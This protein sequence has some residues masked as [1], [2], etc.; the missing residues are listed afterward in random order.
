MRGRVTVVW[1]L[2]RTTFTDWWNDNTFRLSASLAFYTIFS[3]APVVILAVWL[4]SILPS[5]RRYARGET[6]P[7]LES[8]IATIGRHMGY[9]QIP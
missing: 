2:L 4:A 5:P 8:R 7:Y 9:A 3:L 6:T 1:R